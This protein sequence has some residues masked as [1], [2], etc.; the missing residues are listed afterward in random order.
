M[1]KITKISAISLGKLLGLMYGL[2]GV[3]FGAVITSISFFGQFVF[4]SELNNYDF[5][6]GLGA[7]IILPI[8]Y[9]LLGFLLG[10]L[11]AWIYNLIAR[12]TGGLK[13]EIE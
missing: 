13:I 7:I 4:Q 10:L 8:F 2:F 3:I 9:G 6:F 5:L 12:F 11:T 1:K